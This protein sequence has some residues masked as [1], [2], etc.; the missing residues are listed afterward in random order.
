M[1]LNLHVK[2][3]ALIDEIEVTFDNNLNILTGET[4]TGKSIII[5]SISIALGGKMNKDIVRSGAEYGLVELLFSI[6]NQ[7]TIARIKE[8]GYPVDDGEVLIS[9]KIMNGKSVCRLNGESITATNLKILSEYLIDLH[10]QH[11]HQ[12]LLNKSKHLEIL[13][14]F[15]GEALKDPIKEL[16]ST[17]DTLNEYKKK[18]LDLDIDEEKRNREIS[19]IE[20]EISEIEDAKLKKDEDIEI[21]SRYKLMSNS[22]TIT[23]AINNAYELTSDSGNSNLLGASNLIGK[24]IKFIKNVEA[25]DSKISELVEEIENVDTLL[26]DFNREVLDYVNDMTF[27]EEIFNEVEE[28]FDII[29]NLKNK[30]GNSIEDIINYCILQKDRLEILLNSEEYLEEIKSTI[31]TLENKVRKICESITKIRLSKSKIIA[32]QIKNALVELN[33]LDVQ[34]EICM[35]PTDKPTRNGNDD[36]EF[37]IS[38]NPGEEVKPLQ[39]VAS[40]GEL[41]RIM[42]AIK[43][44]LAE[45]DNIETLI[46]DEIDVGISGRTAQKVSE[47]LAVIAKNHQV[48]CITHLPQIAAMADEHYLIEKITN[49]AKTYTNIKRLDDNSSIMEL[50]RLLGGV[51]ITDTAIQNA[52]EMKIMAQKKKV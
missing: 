16:R 40:G 3:L 6:S 26:N 25:F 13:D 33:F 20:Y 9:R 27:D 2:N 38:T 15:C 24:A 41:S 34:F 5:D 42:L 23:S 29:N 30:Y 50:A 43:S 44:V 18:L 37:L 52:N 36:V 48:I 46:F 19:F 22:K 45:N 17:Y 1:L 47:R 51:E 31:N 32:E 28:R 10:G 39:R 4:G 12:S 21:T 11:E 35:K 7:I 14:E 49:K 8:M